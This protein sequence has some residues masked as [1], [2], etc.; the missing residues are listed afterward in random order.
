MTPG[1]PFLIARMALALLE[2]LPARAGGCV[3]LVSSALPGE[4]KSFI[5]GLLARE[6]AAKLDGEVALVD[7]AFGAP[8]Q[9]AGAWSASSAAAPAGGSATGD[10][11]AHLLSHGELPAEALRSTDTP[12]LTRVPAA[13][14]SALAGTSNR[15]LLLFQP[16]AVRRALQVLRQRFALTVLDAAALAGCGALAQEADALVLVVN[17]RR[18]ARHAI[19]HALAAARVEPARIAGVVLN[20][21]VPELPHWLGGT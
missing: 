5:S 1:D 2:R 9:R 3:V 13:A 20:R 6:L 18:T 16:P 7:A 4:G 19:E 12:G 21:H 15:A 14:A 11:F 17:A 10:G 8:L